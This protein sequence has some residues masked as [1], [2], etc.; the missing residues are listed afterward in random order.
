MLG[1]RLRLGDTIGILSPSSP[2]KQEAIE[3]GI[4]LIK[5]LGFNVLEGKH[6]YDHWG[7]LAGSDK[8]RALDLNEF[9]KN[10]QVSA[11]LCVRGGYGAMR[12]LPM[13]DLNIIKNNP[14]LFIGF[15]DITVLLNYIWQETG[16]ITFHGPMASSK[17]ED[18]L[19][20]KSFLETLMEPKEFYPIL[21]PAGYPLTSNSLGK[22]T[23]RLIGGNLSLISSTIG[24]PYAEDFE[25]NI[26]FIEDVAEEPYQ[27]DRM[28]TQLLLSGS[29]DSCSGF[30]LGQFTNCELP[31]YERSLTL[32]QVIEDRLYSLKKPIVAGLMS[33]HDY[34]KLTLPIGANVSI[35]SNKGEINVL[36]EIIS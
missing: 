33:G 23:G 20:L 29:L 4:N 17:L 31:H 32:Q 11:I 24:T 6:I 25:N 3:K 22:A 15:S 36:E 16:L 34:P 18:D 26:L 12:I 10:P 21:N 7:Y 8:D 19:T 2:E 27:V 14:K 30:I 28:L 35:D 5:K 9:F 13:L 1:R